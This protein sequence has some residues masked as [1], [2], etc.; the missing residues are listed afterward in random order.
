MGIRVDEEGQLLNLHSECIEYKGIVNSEKSVETLK[1]YYALLFPTKWV[2]EGFPG[3]VIDAFAAGLPVIAS[4]WNANKEIIEHM[5]QGIIY[6]SADIESLYD[7]VEWSVTHVEEVNQ[8][9]K[10]SRTQF[11]KYMPETVLEIIR[12]AI[13]GV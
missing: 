3:T 5:K 11:T 2:G 8:M 4:D 6:P 7:A 10:G 9:R 13:S 12:E 1:D